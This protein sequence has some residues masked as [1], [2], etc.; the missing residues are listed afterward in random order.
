MKISKR[1]LRRII[2]EEKA[3]LVFEGWEDKVMPGRDRSGEAGEAAEIVAMIRENGPEAFARA[4]VTVL[5]RDAPEILS[6]L[7]IHL[8]PNAHL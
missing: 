4:L 1:Q 8:E 7:P 3:K 6:L 5:D 2:R